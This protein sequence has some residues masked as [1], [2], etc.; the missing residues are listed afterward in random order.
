MR[1]SIISA[2]TRRRTATRR[3]Q[4]DASMRAQGDATL[5]EMQQRTVALARQAGAVDQDALFRNRSSA[6]L[7]ARRRA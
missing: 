3:A 7:V 5:R 2:M 1:A 6:Q 4:L